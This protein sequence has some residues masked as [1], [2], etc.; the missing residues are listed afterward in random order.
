MA[1][2]LPK[3]SRELPSPTVMTA[4]PAYISPEQTGRTNRPVDHR[5]DLYSLGVVFFEALT[6][7][8]PF[9]SRDPL[10][11]VHSHIA[12]EPGQPHELNPAVP[13]VLSAITLKLMAK[14]PEDRYQGALA[15][16][17]DLE[18]CR[19]RFEETGKIDDFPLARQDFSSALKIS[20]DLYGRDRETGLSWTASSTSAGAPRK[21][22]LSRDGP[23]SARPSS[24]NRPVAKSLGEAAG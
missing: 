3:E 6:G 24:S 15:L 18:E 13:P 21:W 2:I 7:A 8:L 4:N 1:A 10:E 17:G 9:Q 16:K 11:L 19:R 14:N 5:T 20:R 12:R 23:V 22:C